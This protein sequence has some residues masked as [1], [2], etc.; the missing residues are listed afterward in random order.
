[1]PLFEIET[2]A[3]IM[4]AWAGDQAEAEATTKAHFPDEDVLR[5]TKRPRDEWVISKRLLGLE[6]SSPEPCMTARDCLVKARGDKFHA[7]RLFMQDTGSDL[8]E[9]QRHIETNMSLGW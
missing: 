6:G 9:A 2:T 4:I 3:H 8:H 7:I 1:M 5:I